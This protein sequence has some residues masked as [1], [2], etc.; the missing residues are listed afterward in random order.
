MPSPEGT[1]PKMRLGHYSSNDGLF[2]LVLDRTPRLPRVLIDGTSTVLE[3]GVRNMGDGVVNLESARAE[4]VLTIDSDGHV[5]LIT[6]PRRDVP[7]RRD[8]SA[9]ALAGPPLPT[10]DAAWLATL[11][12][13]AKQKCTSAIHFEI[14]GNPPAASA[15]G[16]YPA[17]ERAARAVEVV[18][19]DK[20]GQDAVKRRLHG[21]RLAQGSATRLSLDSGIL[22]IEADLEGQSLG[23]FSDEIRAFVESKL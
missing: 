16:S 1:T 6:D 4:V 7:L 3:L 5:S 8:A 18:C 23:P 10:V 19:R 9:P 13:R 12:T 14:V 20:T 2:G 17:L 21:V 15:R 22:S 11:D